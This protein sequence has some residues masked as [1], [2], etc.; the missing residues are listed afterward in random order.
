LVAALISKLPRRISKRSHA[1]R[2]DGVTSIVTISMVTNEIVIEGENRIIIPVKNNN[3][4][5]EALL[6]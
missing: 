4:R 5:Y 3:A 6:K 1:V 2:G